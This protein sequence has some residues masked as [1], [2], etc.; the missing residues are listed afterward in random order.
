M[1]KEAPKSVKSKDVVEALTDLKKYLN[2]SSWKEVAKAVDVSYD[3][4]LSWLYRG[5]IP[6]PITLY[7]IYRK[8]PK[9]SMYIDDSLVN[10]FEE[11]LFDSLRPLYNATVIDGSIHKLYRLLLVICSRIMSWEHQEFGDKALIAQS[12][13][14]E[15]RKIEAKVSIIPVNAPGKSFD[16]VIYFQRSAEF[17]MVDVL[18]KDGGV[19]TER[20]SGILID[21]VWET[22]HKKIASSCNKLVTYRKDCTV[23][24]THTAKRKAVKLKQLEQNP[25][26]QPT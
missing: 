17:F 16:V 26:C 1:N 7:K 9:K 3:A 14:Y 21:R 10:V 11:G 5:V 13:N 4:L 24:D 22:L 8:V 23:I 12:L 2:L 6:R 19:L 18:E 15:S 20:T 25:P